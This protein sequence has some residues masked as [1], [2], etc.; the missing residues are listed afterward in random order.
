MPAASDSTLLL[1]AQLRSSSDADL[2]ELTR[3]RDVRAT[4]IRDFFD[5][6][7]A[8]LE[9]TS[10]QSALARL[11]RAA[12]AAL[13]VLGEL[14]AGH[15]DEFEALAVR[16]GADVARV[17]RG[18]DTAIA[19]GLAVR[20]GDRV[21][22]L[23]AVRTHLETWPGSGLPSGADLI[24]VPA[25]GALAPV[26]R[27]DHSAADAIAAA[28]AFDTVGAV[29]DLLA[30][31]D[32]EPAR[33]LA[34]GGLSLPDSRRLATDAGVDL[35]E[36][37]ALLRIAE[38]A[39]LLER[40][41]GTVRAAPS[42]TD[43]VSRATAQ[44]WGQ[45]A[46]AW[47]DDLPPD[48]RELLAARAHARWGDGLD[49]YVD[50]LYPAGGEWMRDRIDVVSADAARLGITAHHVPST[51]GAAL[52]DDGADPVDALRALL[53]AEIRQAYVQHDLSIVAPGP[54][55][56]DVAERLRRMA[57]LESRGLASTWRISAA[58][59]T[60]A[61][62][63]GETPGDLRDFL[64][65]LALTGIPQ[66]LAYL[67]A[68]AEQRFGAVR[69]SAGPDGRARVRSS[70]SALLRSIE[71][72]AALGSLGL[73]RDD[74]ALVSRFDRDVVFLALSEARYPVAAERADGSTEFPRRPRPAPATPPAPTPDLV[75]RLRES[76]RGSGPVP[77]GDAWMS[78]QIDVAIRGRLALRV[79]V[80][81]PDGSSSTYELEPASLAGG[82]LRARDRRADLERT[83]PLASI[84][85]VEPA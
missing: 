1:A 84:V 55:A 45:L 20:D 62:S 49:H 3:A 29:T 72:D 19:R 14:G 17:R 38:R 57:D 66:P 21:A 42:T 35:D 60:R 9:P 77:T 34:R 6:A 85:E 68:E 53:P 83:L 16:R 56:P 73:T 44:R 5:L 30:S 23:A 65:A 39:H 74:D 24:T 63:G 40:A 11:D 33:E 76:E 28:R 12:L 41:G 71:V 69:V 51:P 46:R 31:L 67:L 22:S 64:T 54:L 13:T 58:S 80:R 78:R 25:P 36:V 79:T 81:L 27:E 75:D 37:P 82:R 70:D 43:W 15:P 4:A 26:R 8:L 50:W 61:L 7:E 2:R 48:I 32:R 52:L 10:V 47:L 59:L 18:L